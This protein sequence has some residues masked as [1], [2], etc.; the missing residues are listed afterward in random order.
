M[1]KVNFWSN[2]DKIKIMLKSL[3]DGLK[4]LP[5]LSRSLLQLIKFLFVNTACS[6]HSVCNL[7]DVVCHTHNRLPYFFSVPHGRIPDR[8][9]IASSVWIDR[10]CLKRYIFQDVSVW[11][12]THLHWPWRWDSCHAFFCSLFKSHF[13]MSM[14]LLIFVASAT[15]QKGVR[16]NEVSLTSWWRFNGR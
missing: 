8:F 13:L 14:L 12:S 5:Y 10:S 4:L 3:K 2:I 16:E 7:I 9:H 1:E 11:Y 6:V 15:F